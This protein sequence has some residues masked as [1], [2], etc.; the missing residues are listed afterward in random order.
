MCQSDSQGPG[1]ISHNYIYGMHC[2]EKFYK[3]CRQ[4]LDREERNSIC[5]I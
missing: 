4:L 2:V 1:K 5:L 3:V